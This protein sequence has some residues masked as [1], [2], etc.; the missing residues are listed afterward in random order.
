M[1][2]RIIIIGDSFSL[3]VGAD[4]PELFDNAHWLAP[5]SDSNWF[6]DWK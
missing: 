1:K 3:G 5:K 6:D 2:K 4:F